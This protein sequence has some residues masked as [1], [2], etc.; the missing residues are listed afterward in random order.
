MA[1]IGGGWWLA[2]AARGQ[3]SKPANGTNT[4]LILA[5]IKLGLKETMKKNLKVQ[6][7]WPNI[8]KS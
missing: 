6:N 1:S 4:V 7:D 2:Q 3:W 5:D 8:Y